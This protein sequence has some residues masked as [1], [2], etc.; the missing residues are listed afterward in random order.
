MPDVP[1]F[2]PRPPAL[3]DRKVYIDQMQSD[4]TTKKRHHYVPITYLKNFSDQ[5][6]RVYA[7]RK[8][9]PDIP[10]HVKPEEIAFER[11]Y[12]SQPTPDGGRD[13]DS[14]EN[15]FS[16]IEGRW[17]IVVDALRRRD[18]PDGVLAAILEFMSLMRV[19]VPA[20]RDMVELSLA[21]TVKTTM[22]QMDALGEFPPKPPGHDDILDRVV[23]GID[24]HQSIHA[25]PDLIDRFERVV[26]FLGFQIVHNETDVDFIT[27]D[28]PVI[29]F[30]PS[31]PEQKV[32]PYPNRAAFLEL[33][34]PIDAR[35]VVRGLL[36]LK[37]DNAARGIRH[38]NLGTAS[39]VRRINRMLARFGYRFIFANSRAHD[40]LVVRHAMYAPVFGADVVAGPNSKP[41]LSYRYVFGPLPKKVKWTSDRIGR[42]LPTSN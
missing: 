6:E 9:K 39:E 12:Y 31:M 42:K 10:L 35:I 32:Q 15:F 5:H 14:L 2:R 41:Q 23:V 37:S 30:D 22:R 11:Y 17:P 16:R 28:N 24:P 7:Y 26:S 29:Y 19:R 34:F 1:V 38:F 21:Q 40:K 33:L 13:N 27:T 3:F 36:Q 25:I 4:S 18:N 8:A 20:A